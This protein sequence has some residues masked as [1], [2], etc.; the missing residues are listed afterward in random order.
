ML[1][2]GHVREGERRDPDRALDAAGS[3]E[4]W[5]GLVRRLLPAEDHPPQPVQGLDGDEVPD[6]VA[7]AQSLL[8]EY[9]ASRIAVLE[10]DVRVQVVARGQPVV[11]QAC[12]LA[13]E[14]H[15][16]QA[17]PLSDAA[18]DCVVEA[19]HSVRL[20]VVVA[21]HDRR[22]DRDDPAHRQHAGEPEHELGVLLR[23]AE[24][25]VVGAVHHHREARILMA[26]LAHQ[27]RRTT[28]HGAAACQPTVAH[29]LRRRKE[30]CQPAWR[31]PW[32]KKSIVRK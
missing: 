30:G 4:G 8:G 12:Q 1:G 32:L 2:V 10:E 31:S 6:V 23:P 21:R 13:V 11:G 28:P 27:R 7:V 24:L 20:R 5:R 9:A 18:H 19:D 29:S 16:G 15:H 22:H 3:P 26:D 17:L 25:H 14:V